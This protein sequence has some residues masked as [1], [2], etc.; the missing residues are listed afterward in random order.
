MISDRLANLHLLPPQPSAVWTTSPMH[1]AA[2]SV[3]RRN[4][5][6]VKVE[7]PL[8][9]YEPPWIQL[10][11]EVAARLAASVANLDVVVSALHRDLAEDDEP[12]E[13]FAPIETEDDG[14][15][16]VSQRFLPRMT[17][18]RSERYGFSTQDFDETLIVD[19]RLSPTADDSGRLAYSPEQMKR[20]ER[21]PEEAPISG[22]GYVATGTFP[23]DVASLK[24]S[25]IKLDQIRQLAP[26]AAVLVSIGCYAL[27]QEVSAALVSRPDGLIVRA[28]QPEIEGIQLAAIVS[29]AR[30]LMDEKGRADAPLWIVPG[31]VTAKDAAK[32][33]ALGASAVA[34]DAWCRPLVDFLL[35]SMPSSRYDRAAFNEIPAVASQHLWDD[36]DHV[37]GLVSAI[38]PQA[39]IA[40]RLGTYHSRW[41]KACG[42]SL[43]KP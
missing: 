31:E 25:R 12:A 32:L 1:S 35:E 6:P 10:P 43:L 2:R 39:T 15:Q 20:W 14:A 9:W 22:G 29:R 28:N 7:V 40:Q 33:I 3:P 4:N 34:I 19:V 5:G 26:S 41:A 16:E 30:K 27:E 17:P 21:T 42:A 11:V 37:I 38:S 24:Q 18:Y 13:L 36:I 23:T 8:F